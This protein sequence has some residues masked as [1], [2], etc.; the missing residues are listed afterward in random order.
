[1]TAMTWN[2]RVLTYPL[3][4][5]W[6]DDY[7]GGEFKLV[8][9]HAIM[10]GGTSV[11]LSVQFHLAS[12][13][14]L[15]MVELGEA[16][17]A[18]E[19]S[20]TKTFARKTEFL[21]SSDTICLPASDYAEEIILSPYL[22]SM[23]SRDSF[24]SVEHTGEWRDYSPQGFLVPEYGILAAGNAV[25]V[26]IENIGVNSVI[27]LVGNANVE[28]GTFLIELDD[29][30]IKIHVSVADKEK[31]EAI[32]NRRISGDAG[33]TGLFSSVYLSAVAEGLRCFD[34]YP[35]YRWS[36]AMRKALEQVC[37]GNVDYESV[38]VAP[39]KYAQM[40]LRQPLGVFL[41]AA[42]NVAEEGEE[43]E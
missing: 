26:T 39:L 22:V 38:A 30:H 16:R 40:I 12:D 36:F 11:E 24:I 7:T 34:E 6:T 4:A 10:R 20:C 2:N 27:D 29:E 9:Q 31:L 17:F 18:L 19:V 8:T 35:S 25:K 14:L 3:L 41:D 42:L 32:R 28:T 13:Y 43:E 21:D 37:E 23:S 5:P 33:Y 15:E 1:M